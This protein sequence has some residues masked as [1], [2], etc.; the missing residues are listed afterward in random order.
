MR[1]SAAPTFFPVFKGYTDGGIVANNPS[2]VAVSKAMAH[3]PFLSANKIAVLSLGAGYFPRHTNVFSLAGTHN[4]HITRPTDLGKTAE[5]LKAGLII[6]IVFL[7]AH[8]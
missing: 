7:I 5:I 3:Y 4:A 6:Y 1:T 2:I 8:D